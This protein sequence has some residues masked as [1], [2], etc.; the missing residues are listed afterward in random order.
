MP[1]DRPISE[2]EVI[3]AL[4]EGGASLDEYVLLGGDMPGFVNGRG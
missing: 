2:A 1:T 3:G 4:T